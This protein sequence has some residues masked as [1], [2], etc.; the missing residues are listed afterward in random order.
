[1]WWDFKISNLKSFPGQNFLSLYCCH[2]FL[3]SDHQ[4]N[5]L[6]CFIS[7]SIFT[8]LDKFGFWG[9][10]GVWVFFSK[11]Q[12][13]EAS[14]SVEPDWLAE[15]LIHNA[16]NC[17]TLFRQSSKTTDVFVFCFLALVWVPFSMYLNL[18]LNPRKE[19]LSETVVK[20]SAWMKLTLCKVARTSERN[21][22]VPWI[23]KSKVENKLAR[24]RNKVFHNYFYCCFLV[25]LG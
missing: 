16:S 9:S 14:I 5:D 4:D 17:M 10:F 22:L 12:T 3:L 1:M 7:S 24:V 8:V 23:L 18:V 20:S 15:D 25:I 21:H 11:H 2:V 6:H 13:K 19:Y